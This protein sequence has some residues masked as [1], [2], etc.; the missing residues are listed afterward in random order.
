MMVDVSEDPFFNSVNREGP[1]SREVV[2]LK[3]SIAQR[4]EPE[5]GE[6]MYV[7]YNGDVVVTYPADAEVNV[8]YAE[9]EPVTV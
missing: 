6:I 9:P 2:R 1:V 5:K 3:P 7:Y 4:T 8:Y